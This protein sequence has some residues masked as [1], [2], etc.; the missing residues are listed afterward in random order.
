MVKINL[1]LFDLCLAVYEISNILSY[2]GARIAQL[3]MTVL[4]AEWSESWILAGARDFSVLQNDQTSSGVHPAS[5][6]M[7]RGEG[8]DYFFRCKAAQE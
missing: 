1:G 5:Y 6:L 4:Q 8:G 3:G 2:R 7:C